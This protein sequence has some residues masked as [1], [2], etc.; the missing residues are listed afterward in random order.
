MSALRLAR[1]A[2]AGAGKDVARRLR[3]WTSL[4]VWLGI[5][6]A[7]G[8]MLKLAFGGPGGG[9]PR[10]T[11]LV[12]VAQ[13]EGALPWMLD[14]LEGAGELEGGPPL[15]I[16]RVDDAE[17][18]VERIEAGRASAFVQLPGDFLDA[19]LDGRPQTLELVTN[20]AERVRPLLVEE[21]LDLLA[22]AAFTL[23]RALGDPLDDLR[24][25]LELADA[26]DRGPS[27]A[28]IATFSAAVNER[29]EEAGELLFPPV[30]DVTFVESERAP[31]DGRARTFEEAFFPTLLMLALVFLASGLS[32]DLWAEK[33]SGTLRRAL[34]LPHGGAGL[35]LGK[36]AA[37]GLLLLGVAVS[38]VA[39]GRSLLGIPLAH[40]AAVAVWATLTAL[41]LFVLL[42]FLQT[43]ASNQRAGALL[44][45]LVATPLAMLGGAFF[46]FEAMPDWLAD[47]GRRTPV[48]WAMIELKMLMR[49]PIDGV[50]LA[51]ACAGLA[52]FVLLFFLLALRRIEGPFGARD[53]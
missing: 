2:W 14:L 28:A 1:A 39:V 13:E 26:E 5:P 4:A 32:E 15:T 41:A 9:T 33:S 8:L 44:T 27:P 35:L 50:E 34:S 51:W 21:T 46:P 20:P 45:N 6:I 38:A 19:L 37:S 29:L 53:A 47:V 43:L 25:E 12:Q 31:E 17:L 36:L 16:E 10:A 40:P 48:G 30:L 22:D 18:A 7:I 23:Q 3:D 52:A 49:G 11:L 42:V 24:A